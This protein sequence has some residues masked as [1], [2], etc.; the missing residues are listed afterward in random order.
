MRVC[1]DESSA[2]SND[3]VFLRANWRD[4]HLP[5]VTAV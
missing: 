2:A 4:R 5:F 1:G 3:G